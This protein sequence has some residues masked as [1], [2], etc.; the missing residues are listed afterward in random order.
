MFK[1]IL[2]PLDGSKLAEAILPAAKSM[3]QHLSAKVTLLHVVE[4]GGPTTIH[5]EAHLPDAVAAQ[6]YLERL[7]KEFREQDVQVDWH[8]DVVERGNVAKTIF[9]HTGELKTDLVMLTTHG[10][11]GWRGA[12]FGSIAQQVLQSGSVPVFMLRPEWTPAAFNPKRILVPLDGSEAHEPGLDLAADLAGYFEARLHLV[13]VV[14]TMSTLSA[15]RAATGALL[16][17]STKA[18]LDLAQSGA[19]EYVQAKVKELKARGLDASAEVERGAP[20]AKII[21]VASRTNAGLIVMGT[22]GR[23]GLAA[24]WEGSVTPKVMEKAHA[25]VLLLRVFGPEPMK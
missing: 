11:N 20:D 22:H 5:G 18:M 25:P 10:E 2:V 9:A 21:E 12:V 7:V 24:F 13:V 19:V 4:P 15:E 1:N 16:P 23:A 14:P 6:I 8:V 17:T 3:A